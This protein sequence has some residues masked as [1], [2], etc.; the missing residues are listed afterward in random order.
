MKPVFFA[1]LFFGF[2]AG[3]LLTEDESKKKPSLAPRL[4]SPRSGMARRRAGLEDT[5]KGGRGEIS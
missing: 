1:P 3:F 2:I 4:P 5:G